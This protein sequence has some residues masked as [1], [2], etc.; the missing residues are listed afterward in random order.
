[1]LTDFKFIQLGPGVY[2]V[3]YTSPKT[4][5]IWAKKIT[6]MTIIDR[7][8]NADEPKKRDIEELKRIIKM[9]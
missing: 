9:P 5:R 3:T 1:M 8:K 6:D 7:T 2:T 4:G